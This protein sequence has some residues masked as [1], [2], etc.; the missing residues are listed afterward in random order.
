MIS[1]L[2]WSEASTSN[3]RLSFEQF[4]DWKPEDQRYE[5]LNG[6]PTPMQPTGQHEAITEFLDSALTLEARRMGYPYRFPKQALVQSPNRESGYVPDV[7]VIDRSAL[8]SEP[9]WDTRS[10]LTLGTSI[11][12]VAEVVSR[13]WRNDSDYKFYDYERL[14]IPE[15]WI[16]DYLGVGGR[17][18]LGFP[19]QP[20][21]F[22]YRLVEGEYQGQIYRGTDE[23]QSQIFPELRLTAQ[24]IF[25]AEE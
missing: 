16:I 5:L 23:L 20:T 2:P 1:S 22:I 11:V 18:Y 6:T 13:N 3:P 24:Q 21:L 10:T 14:G 15:Y 8:K 7:L 12:L 19:K 4:L 17:R 9:L 25:Q